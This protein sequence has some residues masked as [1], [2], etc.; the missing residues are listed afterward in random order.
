MTR[1]D[2]LYQALPLAIAYLLLVILYGWQTRGHVTP[3]LFTDELKLAEIS[4]SISE[5][6]HG[7]LRGHPSGFQTLYAYLLAPFWKIGDVATAYATIKYV[8]VFVMTS[9]LF[10]TYFLARTILSK[11]WALFAAIGAV[12]T[13]AL[14]YAPFLV[15]EPAAYPWAAL[16][17]FL[18]AKALAV[19]TR[20]W[21]IGAAAACL[22]APAV[23]GELAVLIPVYALAV[24]FLLL[25]SARFKAWRRSW[26]VGDWVGAVVLGIGA[27]IL[28]SAVVGAHSQ[29]WFI[30]TG[31]YRHRTIVYGLWAAGAFTIG[32]GVLPVVC[33]AALV[34]PRGEQWT[35]ELK[36]YV[37][38]TCA[39]L[40]AFGLYTATKA[41]YLSTK[42][43]TV[44]AERNLIYLAP[45]LFVATGLALERGRLRL[46]AVLGTAGFCLYVILTTPYQLDL[47]PYSD[48]LGFSIVQMA[49]RDLAMDDRDVTWLLVVVLIVSVAIL[50]VPRLFARPRLT[51]GIAAGAA[52][53]VIAWG[54][55]G[56]ISASNGTNNFSQVLL[57][58]FPSPPNWL[59]KATGRKPAIFL[60]QNITDPQGI[61][62]MEFWNRSLQYVWSLDATAPGPGTTPPG[63]LTPDLAPGRAARRPD[64]RARRAA[65]RE[66]HRRRPG[67]QGR[68]EAD[69]AAL[70]QARDH[71][72]P[73]RLPDP[74]GRRRSRP[75]GGCCR[76][77]SRCGSRARR[78]GS[79]PTG[80]PAG[81][82][83]T[84]SSPRPG[85]SPAG[86]RCA[87]RGPRSTGRTRSPAT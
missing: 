64:D 49:N 30:S 10:P 69:R 47:W 74:Q 61:W 50:V 71:R 25:T 32:L 48:A 59:D 53:L 26:S 57:S 41:S 52:A 2:R 24:I 45:L 77:A 36:A 51:T 23:R 83:R 87:S 40:L 43:S 81:P 75:A 67:H 46:W 35:R 28:F 73:V 9:A 18:V 22:L 86:S 11:P 63:Y 8:G 12:A 56:E 44:V 17:L 15:E 72:G 31:F 13:P 78:S 21:A 29:T 27:I 14:A 58:N 37:S 80:G 16:S 1:S 54:L 33:L 34:R 20:W 7:E 68:R 19:R 85:T 55:T 76:S 82:A 42:F 65:G 62:L 39:A 60:G 70:G 3:W 6:G 5:T 79:T 38:L 66:L 84:T 4:R